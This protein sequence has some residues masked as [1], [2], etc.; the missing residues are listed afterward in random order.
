MATV[1]QEPS[2]RRARPHSD[3][4]ETWPRP[5]EKVWAGIFF[6]GLI[7]LTVVGPVDLEAARVTAAI[8][9]EEG[10]RRASAGRDPLPPTLFAD[11]PRELHQL[12]MVMPLGCFPPEAQWIRSWGDGRTPYERWPD[13]TRPWKCVDADLRPRRIHVP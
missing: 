2:E 11:D 5:M 4:I 13:G 10:A 1:Q 7:Y 3:L 8:T 12:E 6:V 9:E